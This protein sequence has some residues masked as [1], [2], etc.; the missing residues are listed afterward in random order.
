MYMRDSPPEN[1]VIPDFSKLEICA[2][3]PYNIIQSVS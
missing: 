2:V 1:A 3:M